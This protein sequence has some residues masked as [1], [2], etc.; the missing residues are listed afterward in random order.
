MSIRTGINRTLRIRGPEL[1][2]FIDRTIAEPEANQVLVEVSACGICGSDLR[3]YRKGELDF[4]YFGHEF[5]GIVAAVG[6]EIGDFHPGDRVASGLALGCGSCD[7]CLRGFPNFC[8]RA[9][10][11]FLP[12]GFAKYCLV[13]CAEGCRPLIGIPD[14]LDD[15][16]AT[17][18][19][20]LSCAMRIV[21]RADAVPGARILILGLGMMGVLSGLLFK[22]KSP[23]SHVVG[24]DT[25]PGR[26][27]T[28][29]RLRFDHCVHLES[30]K[31]APIRDIAPDFD[32]VVDATGAASVF[33]L[34]LDLA[35]LGGRVVLAGVPTESVY[36]ALLP[37]FRK[38]LTVL[39]AKGPYPFP[40]EKGGSQALDLLSSSELPW[41]ELIS[42]FSFDQAALAFKKSA[43]G[44]SLKSVLSWKSGEN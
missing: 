27:D 36:F 15:I 34:A 14:S 3:P 13:T 32:L 26:V 1:L 31:T 41:D 33:P 30:G 22:N 21:E 8:E 42:A 25:H 10:D 29:K 16:R 38:E 24:A 4:P 23:G 7:P 18:F 37:I 9:R 43:E 11:Q 20:P 40:D 28:A 39:G 44:A 5:S 6:G 12:G 17:C 2:E 19:E 35:R